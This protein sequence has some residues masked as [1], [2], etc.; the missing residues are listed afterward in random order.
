LVVM[1]QPLSDFWLLAAARMHCLLHAQTWQA[2]CLAA[3]L[4]LPLLAALSL[5]AAARPL[6]LMQQW[7]LWLAATRLLR[8]S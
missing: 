4:N 6:S 5:Q 3:V 8:T 7:Q 2:C 1:L